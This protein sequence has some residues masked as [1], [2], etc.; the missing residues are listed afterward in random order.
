MTLAHDVHGSGP[1]V[2]LLHSTVGDRRMWDPQIGRLGARRVIRCDLPGY[3]E[4]PVAAEPADVAALVLELAGPQPVAL[5]GSSGGGQVALEIAARWPARVRGLALLCAAA[6][7]LEPSPRLRAMWEQ[8]ETL[9]EAGDVEAAT[10]LM[11]RSWVGPRATGET[12]ALVRRMQQHAYEV[13]LAAA[14]VDDL[15]TGW[16][17]DTVAAPVLLVTGAHDLPDFHDVAAGLAAR[18]PRARH[19][20]L[21]W[22][23]HLPSL[24]DPEPVNRLLRDFLDSV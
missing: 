6:P 12:R 14:D 17:V 9:L 5:I 19:V 22:A 8:E 23:G 21:D 10:E 13:Q 2:L 7:S 20:E 15:D 18:L 24:E 1:E 11:V 4:S 3:G 16:S